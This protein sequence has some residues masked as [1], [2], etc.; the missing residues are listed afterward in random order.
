MWVPGTDVGIALN[1]PPV[2]VPGF[3]SQCSSL[4][5]PP[6]RKIASTRFWA[7]ARSLAAADVVSP[8]NPRTPAEP[9]R[10]V[11]REIPWS[12]V[13]HVTQN[14]LADITELEAFRKQQEARG[15]KLAIYSLRL[16]TDPAIHPVHARVR[17]PVAYLPEYLRNDPLRV[18]KAWWKAR[19]LPGSG[20]KPFLYSAALA[21]NFTPAS[22]ILDAPVIVDD[23]SVEEVWR[24][25]NSGGGLHERFDHQACNSLSVLREQRLGL[26]QTFFKR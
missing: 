5:T 11:R 18:L 24:P 10:N 6:L 2:S 26:P 14:D 7:L 17:A 13:P 15:L 9:A 3:G 23:P 22:V 19:R 12:L 20:F 8:P 21:G 25:K 1:G 16:P 4:P